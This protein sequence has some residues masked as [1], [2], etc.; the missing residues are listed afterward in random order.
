MDQCS[1]H[2]IPPTGSSQD[3]LTD[4]RHHSASG[5]F[6]AS[7]AQQRESWTTDGPNP[8]P[9]LR[10]WRAIRRPMP[11]PRASDTIAEARVVDEDSNRNLRSQEP[12]GCT[13]C[14]DAGSST[15]SRHPRHRVR[16]L[17]S[18]VPGWTSALRS[19]RR[20]RAI[21]DQLPGRP[22]LQP[23]RASPRRRSRAASSPLPRPLLCMQM[24]SL[25]VTKVGTAWPVRPLSSASSSTWRSACGRPGVRGSA[26]PAGWRGR[27]GSLTSRGQTEPPARWRSV[28]S[29]TYCP[30]NV[31]SLFSTNAAAA[32]R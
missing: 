2:D 17:Q 22:T 13:A 10:D 12:H 4:D 32:S 27:P 26:V 20:A 7:T 5:S 29:P 14:V 28:R 8:A 23:N 18:A 6:P 31:A 1:R 19:Y 3:D 15:E 16:H 30:V 11:L 25:L 9:Y 21:H 24:I